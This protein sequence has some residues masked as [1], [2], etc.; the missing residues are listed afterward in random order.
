[1]AQFSELWD[2]GVLDYPM[3]EVELF[4]WERVNVMPLARD[5]L[6]ACLAEA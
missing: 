2:L 4:K 3:S 5:G 1:M 6:F